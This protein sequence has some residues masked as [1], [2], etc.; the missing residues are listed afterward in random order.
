MSTTAEITRESLSDELLE[1]TSRAFPDAVER[2]ARAVAFASEAHGDQVRASGQ[3]YI[4]HPIEVAIILLD[5]G[6]DEDSVIAAVLHDVIEDTAITFADLREAFGETVATLVEGVSKLKRVKRKSKVDRANLDEEQA[7]NLRKMVLAMVDDLRVVIIKLA[8][9]LH[10]MRTLGFLPPER[11]QRVAR[12]TMDVFA[13]L[14]NRLGIWQLKWQLEDLAFH[15][16]ESDQYYAIARLV[17]EQRAQRT[18]YLER[19]IAAV[20]ARLDQEGLNYRITG[21]SKHLYSVYSKMQ[22]KDREFDQIYDLHGIRI[23]VDQERECYHALG[24]IHSLWRPIA[25]EFDDYIALPK[26]NGYQS[27]HT[28]VIALEG[29]P[30]EVQIRTEEMHQVAEYGVAAHWR[31]KEGLTGNLDFEQRLNLLLRARE[32]PDESDDA[33]QFASALKGDLFAERVYVFTPKGDIVDLPAGA[34][35]VDFAYLIHSE[36][37]HRCRGAKIDGRLV[38]LDY[39]LKTGDQVEIV[40]AKQ[41]G[42]SRDWLN[43]HL[44]YVA[45]QRARQKI[46]RWFRAQERDQNI[47]QGREMLDRELRRLGFDQESYAEIAALFS[48]DNVEDFMEALGFGDISPAQIATKIDQASGKSDELRLKAI[49]ERAVTDIRVKG[50]GDLYTRMATCCNPVPGDDIIGYITRG[51]GVTVHRVD[52]PNMV[53]L[54]DRERLVSV[55]WGEARDRYPVQIEIQGI[56]RRGFLRDIAAEIADLG[57]NMSSAQVTT[58]SDNTATVALTVSVDGVSQLSAAMSRLQ[59]IRD[60][61]DVRRQRSG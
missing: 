23:I 52:C 13:P 35:P 24:A 4:I 58:H 12:E 61:L 38:S 49:P 47:T 60:V 48:Y 26:D 54:Q 29:R 10:N 37:G 27:L 42:P 22:E 57:L 7:E 8:D 9:R 17:A 28:A 44:N 1:R 40:T 20:R 41:G 14:A 45:T 18:A 56:D 15:Y 55:S 25:G 33:L 50:V 46:R 53:H 6:M 32:L 59:G 11:Q 51:K 36:I 19:A 31:Y 5:L 30:L 16:L 3:P 39:Q 21:R 43:P 34:T 2:V